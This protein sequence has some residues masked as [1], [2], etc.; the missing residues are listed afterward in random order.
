MTCLLPVT[1]FIKDVVAV[2]ANTI[3]AEQGWETAALG[4]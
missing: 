1:G 2:S 3:A 4:D